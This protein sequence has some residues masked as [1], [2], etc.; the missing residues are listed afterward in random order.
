MEEAEDLETDGFLLRNCGEYQLLKERGFDK[1]MI[2][3]HNLY[4]FNSYA[5]DFW[6]ERGSGILRRLSKRMTGKMHVSGPG[7]RKWKYMVPSRSWFS[8]QCLFK[9]AGQCRKDSSISDLTDRFGN[10]F[11]VR[12]HC[13][14]CYN[15]IYNRRPRHLHPDEHLTRCG[16]R[17][18]LP[19]PVSAVNPEQVRKIMSEYLS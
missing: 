19:H 11:P 13:D 8:A 1:K 17:N 15:V 16:G 5:A 4:V 3:D 7:F 14:F 2:L 12:A 9:T 6:E 10:H 18:G